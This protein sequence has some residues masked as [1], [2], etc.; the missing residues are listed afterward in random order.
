MLEQGLLAASQQ[1]IDQLVKSGQ[2]PADQA[3][4]VI[5]AIKDN[6]PPPGGS[7]SWALQTLPKRA[8]P[9]EA[10]IV[11]AFLA[12]IEQAAILAKATTRVDAEQI[13][14][15]DFPVAVPDATLVDETLGSRDHRG[16][17]E[18][19]YRHVREPLEH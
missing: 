6:L 5:Q 16:R 18:E 10:R 1:R 14:E 11:H 9:V 17:R 19:I 15:R 2:L 12:R 8:T 7:P 4:E 13:T 3:G